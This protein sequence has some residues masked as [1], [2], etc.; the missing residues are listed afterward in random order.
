MLRLVHPKPADEATQ[1]HK[2]YAD[3]VKTLHNH[4]ADLNQTLLQLIKLYEMIRHT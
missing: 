3:A 1:T 4:P 2:S